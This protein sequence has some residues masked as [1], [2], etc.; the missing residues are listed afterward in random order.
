MDGD[1][2]VIDVL[3][4]DDLQH[5]T[6]LVGADVE[7]PIDLV[8]VRFDGTGCHGVVDRVVDV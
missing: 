1:L 6:C 3:D 7:H 2:A 4:G 5:A 8:D